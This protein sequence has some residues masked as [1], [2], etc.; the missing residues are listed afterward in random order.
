MLGNHVHF[1]ALAPDRGLITYLA[2]EDARHGS[3]GAKS[4]APPF[5]Q[6]RHDVEILDAGTARALA[7]IVEPRDQTG[8]AAVGI[9]E[10]KVDPVARVRCAE[11]QFAVGWRF[12]H[13]DERV[14]DIKSASAARSVSG[15]PALG[16]A[17]SGSWTSTTMPRC[18]G[19]TAAKTAARPPGRNAPASRNMLVARGSA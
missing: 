12:A 16:I 10:H 7:Q 6:S 18:A 15:A 13:D 5:P 11:Q 14:G 2:V 3:L 4:A 9:T 8:L 19:I 1:G 17:A